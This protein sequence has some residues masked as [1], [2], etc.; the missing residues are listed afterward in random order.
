LHSLVESRPILR[1]RRDIENHEAV[2]A[3]FI[4]QAQEMIR[5]FEQDGYIYTDKRYMGG[6]NEASNGWNSNRWR[7]FN[8]GEVD[9]SSGLELFN[10][11]IG[12]Y[13][14]NIGAFL[15]IVEA[16]KYILRHPVPRIIYSD[17]IT[18]IT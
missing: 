18:A 12:N 4:K 6:E 13:T 15:A 2:I 3:D 14:N 16:V 5:R 11:S 1:E 9:L 17:S 8:E 7:S 10:C